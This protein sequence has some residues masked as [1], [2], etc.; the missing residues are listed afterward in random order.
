MTL[1]IDY[2]YIKA[3]QFLIGDVEVDTAR[4]LLFGTR[5]QLQHLYKC[6]RWFKDGTFKLVK[7]PFYQLFSVH[8][9]IKKDEDIKQVPLMFAL[10]S[11]RTTADYVKVCRP[12]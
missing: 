9:Y 11:R 5:V 12:T 4:H 3:D 7:R 1:Q 8:G 2:A 6:K 10:M